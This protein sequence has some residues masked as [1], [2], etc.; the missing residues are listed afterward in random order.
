MAIPALMRA[1]KQ[2][3]DS[4]TG[5]SSPSAVRDVLTLVRQG[6]LRPMR[7]DKL[8]R[9]FF[10]W[11]RW[12]ITP[13]LGYAIGAIRHPDR[14]ALIDDRGALSYAEVSQRTTRLA[15]GLRAR[16]IRSGSRVG[17]LCR[18]HHGPVETMLACAKLGA[19]VV[20][21]NTGLNSGQLTEVLAQQHIDLLVLDSEFT[22]HLDELPADLPVVL[23]WT[24]GT[25]QRS[26]LE[27]LIGRS[28]LKPIDGPDRHSKMIVLTSGT[29]GAP[30]GAA[31]PDPPGLSP[32]ATI[33]S[34]VPLRNGERILLCAPLFHTWG[35]AAFQLGTVI[36][37]TLVLRRKFEPQQTLA[38]VQRH[39]CTAIFAVPI[40]LQRI[41]DLPDE[42]RAPYDDSS[43]RIVASSGSALPAD[44]ATRFQR[45]FGPILYNFYGSTEVSW[46]S[47]ATPGDL[48]HA[49]GT[50]GRPP[51]G[52]TLRIL[53]TDGSSPGIGGTGRIFVANDMLFEG[54][55]NG[56]SKETASGLMSTGDLGYLDSDGRLF[57]VGREDDMIVSGGENI[58]PRETEDAIATLPGVADVAVIG[59][60]DAEFG[61][62]LAAFVVPYPGSELDSDGIR[63]QIRPKLP[64]FAL[65]RDVVFLDELPRNATGKVVPRELLGRLENRA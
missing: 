41:L 16:G 40:M 55:T 46:V 53:D 45:A 35:I 19:D 60:D 8:L 1:L 21:I 30:K 25:T 17:I 33:M 28:P 20:L 26:T 32:A 47:I 39:R 50:A 12:G 37:A 38:S 51:R 24:E 13:P 6:V 14:P 43:L 18:N 11:R 5:A 48:Q 31:R 63:G 59:V 64:K 29:T 15:H 44:L 62:R 22:E 65:P 58:Y 3:A 34:R 27:H 10:A 49:P 7:P 2:R 9:I 23:A 52:T 57:I 42:A 56:K 54:Y 61:Q 4:M 36:G